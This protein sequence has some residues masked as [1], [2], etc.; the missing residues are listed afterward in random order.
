MPSHGIGGLAR[1]DLQQ[2]RTA[3]ADSGPWVVVAVG[4]QLLTLSIVQQ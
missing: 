2:R 1:R 4:E 3:F